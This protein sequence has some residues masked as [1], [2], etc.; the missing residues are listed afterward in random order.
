MPSV[1]SLAD[2][3]RSPR[4]SGWLDTIIK[5]DCVAA[6]EALPDQSVDVIFA[7]P[8]YNLQLGGA[9]HRPDQSL[10][11]ACDD[12]WDQFA[13]FEAYDAFTRAWLLACRRVLKP[14]GTIWVIGSYHNIF[15]VGAT[16]QDLNFWI[17]NDIVWRKA[18]PMPNFKG[19]RFQNAHETMIWATRDP[20]AKGYT[21][22]YDAMK[23]ANDDVQMRSDWLFPICNGG[24]RLKDADGK[25][26]HPTQ[27]P[28]ALLARILMASSKPGDVVLDPFFGSGTTGAVAKRLGRHFVGIEREQAYIDAARERIDAVEPL[29]SGTLSVM[30]GKK[31]EPRVAF[32]T[33]IESGLIAPG[34]VLTDARRRHSAIV[35]ADGTLASGN[36]AGSIH[37]LGAKVQ[38]LDACNGWT[39][40]HYADGAELKPIDALRAVIRSEMAGLE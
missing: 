14:S 12:E 36:D 34:T 6:L 4:K 21:F 39:F 1:L 23:A 16:L 27:K 35:R 5:G 15:R 19:R 22:N 24:E 26:V 32:N 17:L 38:G 10:V 9:L 40:W 3:S 31:A 30:S 28:E 20:K 8:P 13:S 18:N 2:V 11:D 33:L 25:K 29:G 7:D 37:R